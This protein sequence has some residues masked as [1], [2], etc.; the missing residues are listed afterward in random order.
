MCEALES[1]GCRIIHASEPNRAPFVITFETLTGERMGVVA[2]AFL[3]TRTVTKNRP[4][5]ERSFQVK[6]GSKL[7]N[8][9]HVIFQDQLVARHSD[10]DRLNP[11]SE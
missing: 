5:D 3:A 6:Y 1:Q 9:S 11:H 7:K 2:Y 8:N 10:F 4:E